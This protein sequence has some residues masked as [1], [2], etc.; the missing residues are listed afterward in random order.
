LI[1]R[2]S[3]KHVHMHIRARKLAQLKQSKKRVRG[4]HRD[5]ENKVDI[6]AIM[7]IRHLDLQQVRGMLEE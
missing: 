1:G 5:V 2:S 4:S 7:Y 6:M 3:H